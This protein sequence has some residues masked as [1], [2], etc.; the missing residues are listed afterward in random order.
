MNITAV[1]TIRSMILMETGAN[2]IC[3]KR[4]QKRKVEREAK[5]K[6]TLGAAAVVGS[7]LMAVLGEG[8]SPALVVAGVALY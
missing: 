8:G 3:W 1:T 5:L 4:L 6:K 7:I 2:I